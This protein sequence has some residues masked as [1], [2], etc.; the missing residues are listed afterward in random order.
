MRARLKKKDLVNESSL[1]PSYTPSLSYTPKAG[2]SR[3]RVF[4]LKKKKIP[5]L[6]FTGFGKTLLQPQYLPIRPLGSA[7]VENEV[8][9][10]SDENPFL[11]E[12]LQQ[13]DV[14]RHRRKRENQWTRWKNDIIPDLLVPYMEH[15]R[16]SASLRDD[17]S[18]GAVSCTSKFL[19]FAAELFVN[20]APNTTAWCTTIESFLS[21]RGYKLAT[22]GSLRKRFGNALLWY[23]VLKDA[24]TRVL[25][26]QINNMRE[27][28]NG[29][30][31][32]SED[33]RD[34]RDPLSSP[35]MPRNTARLECWTRGDAGDEGDK[36]NPFG[37]PMAR[38]RIEKERVDIIVCLDA[39]F[40]QKRNR[41]P[42]DPPLAHPHT[43]FIDETQVNK[44][45]AYVESLR[46]S[47]SHSAKQRKRNPPSDEDG[48]E[49][50]LRV[51]RSILDGCEASFTAADS[52]RVKASTQF[53]DDTALMALLCR[54]DIVLFMVNMRS[55][56]E[57][58]HYALALIESLF[59]HL[60]HDYSVGLLY[61]IACQLERSCI[62]WGFLER[63]LPRL[64]F[65][66][67]VFHAFG[68][69]WPC[70]LIYHPRKCV[71][72]GLSDGEGCERFWHSISKL[73]AYL[74][75]CGYHQRL[76][77][78]DRQVDHTM[79]MIQ[80][81]LGAWLRRRFQHSE[82]K[83]EEAEETLRQCGFSEAILRAEW[84]DQ[85]KTQTKPLKRQS[86]DSGKK[87]ILELIQLRETR[88]GF[89]RQI[90]EYNSLLADPATPFEVYV[91]TDD[92]CKKLRSKLAE[93][94]RA[95]A[96]TESALSIEDNA[97]LTRLLK[98]KYVALCVNALG[99]K[100]RLRDKLR[101]HKFELE[102]V[103][104]ALRKQ[105]NDKKVNEHTEASV[106]R[107]EPSIAQLA[108]TYNKLC[109]KLAELFEAGKAPRNALLPQK[110]EAK[111]LFALDVDDAIWQDVGLGIDGGDQ[112]PPVWLSNEKAREGI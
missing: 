89:K 8:I 35:C 44:F 47:R 105:M 92:D 77:T 39:C 22:E 88:E 83:R 52:R 21:K 82:R 87:V 33:E 64:R 27:L 43:V 38:H 49:G 90:D 30:Q 107:R 76:Y 106:K 97:S 4:A 7:P 103:E 10:P 67:S 79:T 74:R 60:P 112:S 104:R 69:Q 58:Q 42:R 72:F 56:G 70:Q 62:K 29:C 32:E 59:Q 110:I 91:E 85:V 96:H 12:P 1:S 50:S 3:A 109:D 102:R 5:A 57:K 73:I 78:L 111:G 65:G 86:K 31:V 19:E 26:E 17:V 48:F 98:N 6:V 2:P 15:L 108:S 54:H 20:I 11:D 45:E 95:I 53:F 63:Y 100:E 28:D 101:S 99:V 25:D 23:N 36:E 37:E 51:P 68:H 80:A 55:A 46:P 81:R 34:E 75:V 66:I 18:V 71:G 13:D 40:T 93:L 94:T 16:K 41:Q 84:K 24:T 61:D 14:S 9:V